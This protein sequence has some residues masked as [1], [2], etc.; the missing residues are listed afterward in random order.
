MGPSY[1]F[2]LYLAKISVPSGTAVKHPF[3]SRTA[4][5]Q[6]IRSISPGYYIA[7]SAAL[8]FEAVSIGKSRSALVPHSPTL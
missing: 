2:P 5:N 4:L 8:F 3:K 6:R 7:A 1:L